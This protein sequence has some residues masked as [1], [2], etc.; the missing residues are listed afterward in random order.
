M[1]Y[2]TSIYAEDLP[3]RAKAA[4]CPAVHRGTVHDGPR[5]GSTHSIESELQKNKF[6]NFIGYIQNIIRYLKICLDNRCS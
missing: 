5:M 3:H 1:G 4:V 2:F 6:S